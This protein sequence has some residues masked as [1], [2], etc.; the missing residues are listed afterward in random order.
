MALHAIILRDESNEVVERIE[1]HYPENYAINATCFFVRTGDIS[2]KVAV[3]VGIKGD[4]RVDDSSG[5]V[6][7][8]NGAYSGHTSRSLWEWLEE[9]G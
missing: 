2:D 5:A 4:D 8:L 7:K 1:K 3:N 9:D 6:F